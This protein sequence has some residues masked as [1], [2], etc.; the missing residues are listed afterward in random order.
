MNS[1]REEIEVRDAE[2]ARLKARVELLERVAKSYKLDVVSALRD[3]EMLHN[4]GKLGDVG[5]TEMNMRRDGFKLKIE[6]IDD[7]I[8][9]AALNK[10][11][12]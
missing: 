2:I 11:P 1:H 4:L 8:G 12:V 5:A 9:K 6:I 3:L 10:E 7:A